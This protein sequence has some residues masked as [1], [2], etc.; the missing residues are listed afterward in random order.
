MWDAGNIPREDFVIGCCANLV[1]ADPT[2]NCVRF[3]HSSVK[4]YL[5][6]DRGSCIKGYPI[7]IEQGEFE[8]GEFCVAYLSFSNFGLQL[9]TNT[10]Q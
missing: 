6:R 8:C 5:D 4:Q 10:P 2:D 9:E 3:A 1:V 7:S